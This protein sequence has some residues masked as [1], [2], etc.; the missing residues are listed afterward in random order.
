M[1]I[2]SNGREIMFR[3]VRAALSKLSETFVPEYRLTFIG[4]LPGCSEA[5]ILVTNEMILDDIKDVVDRTKSRTR[6]STMS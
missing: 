3:Q 2:E 1:N 6:E 4:R 5:D